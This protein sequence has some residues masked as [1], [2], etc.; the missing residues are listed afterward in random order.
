[1][2]APYSPMIMVVE[3][4]RIVALNLCRSLNKLGYNA[5]IIVSNGEDALRSIHAHKPDVVLMDIHIDGEMDGIE[6]AAHIPQDLMVPVIYLTAYTEEATLE[7]ARQT[8]PYGYLVK[9]FSERELH[10]TIKMALHRRESDIAVRRSEERLRLALTAAELGS[11]E[12]QPDTS[13]IICR[14]HTDWVHGIP[15]HQAAD[16]LDEFLASLHHEDREMVKEAYRVAHDSEEM[17]EVEF[18]RDLGDGEMRWYRAAGKMSHVDS[19]G[20][21]RLLGVIRDIT[22]FKKAADERRHSDQNYRDLISTI[23]GIVWEADLARDH[24]TYVSDSTERILGYSPTDWLTIPLFWETHVHPDDRAQ[25]IAEYHLGTANTGSYQST[26]RMIDANGDIVWIHEV[27][28][29]IDRNG[30]TNLVRGLMVDIT[31]LKKAESDIEAA[32][33]RLAE[34]EKR[35]ATIL[36]TAAVGIISIDEHL[37]IIAFNREAERIFGYGAATMIGTTLD[38]LI[39]PHLVYAHQEHMKAFL[40]SD[41]VSREMGDWREVQGLHANGSVIPLAAIISRVEVAGRVTLTAIMRDMTQIQKSEMELRRLLADRE[42]A[43]ERAEEASRAK[44]SF[45][46]VMSHEL[47]TPLN[48][49]IGFSELMEREIGGPIDNPSYREYIAD[50]H[51]SGQL[52]LDHVNGILDLSRIESGKHDLKLSPVT[53]QDVW[54]PISGTLLANAN[55][56]GVELKL[57]EPADQIVLK[58]DVKAVCQIIINLVSN[59]IKFTPAGGLVEVGIAD[60]EGPTIFVRD[61]GRGIPEDKLAD[62]VKPFYQV[63]DAMVRDTG[64]VGLGLAIC[65]SLV[66]AMSGRIAINSEIGRGTTVSVFLPRWQDVHH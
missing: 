55:T 65:K 18:R 9:P 32:N 42:L 3:D 22:I 45:L 38:R 51:Q 1:M 6:T 19:D 5:S 30:G 28:S 58:A 44:S 14:S 62:V 20:T 29:V 61:T 25:A 16:S 10:A 52:L 2:N 15:G 63:S 37:R 39:P 23:N 11:W 59:G 60:V 47:R 12:V 21:K 17:C 48:A 26:Y 34:S 27:V 46:A 33:L 56:K 41:E 31:D 4:E 13:A 49:I 35:L 40:K 64:G 8:K 50:I 43:V 24:M 66:E 53:L 54:A 57:I 36:D 7:R